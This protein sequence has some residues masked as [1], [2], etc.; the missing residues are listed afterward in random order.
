MIGHLEFLEREH[1]GCPEQLSVAICEHA[2][3]SIES[4]NEK[5]KETE[6][7]FFCNL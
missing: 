1:H 4:G 3:S 7:L 2:M 6:D 5:S